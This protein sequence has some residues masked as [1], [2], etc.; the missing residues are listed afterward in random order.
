MSPSLFSCIYQFNLF[1]FS[2]ILRIETLLNEAMKTGIWPLNRS[3]HQAMTDRIDVDVINMTDEIMLVTNLMFPKTPLP[4][5][6]LL[7]MATGQ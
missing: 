7:F 2:P 1:T 3:P 6:L 4:D 5:R